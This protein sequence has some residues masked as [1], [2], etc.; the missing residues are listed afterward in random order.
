MGAKNLGASANADSIDA[1][2]DL[3]S[4]NIAEVNLGVRQ[5]FDLIYNNLVP[6]E[7]QCYFRDT[8]LFCLYKDPD[9][10]TKLHPI[11]IPS[12]MHRIITSHVSAYTRQ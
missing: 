12:A 5:L 2:V 11:G 10:L 4:L 8:Y 6:T 3:I 7:L 9:D 1:F